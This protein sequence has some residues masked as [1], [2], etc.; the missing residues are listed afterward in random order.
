MSL[1]GLE[2]LLRGLLAPLEH[3][4]ALRVARLDGA[5]G[6]HPPHPHQDQLGDVEVDGDALLLGQGGLF[7]VE[8]ALVPLEDAVDDLLHLELHALPE[9]LGRQRPHLHEGLALPLA[10]VDG[11]DRGLVLL[12]RDLA[13]ADEDLAQAVVREVA[14]GEYDTPVHEVDALAGAA[15]DEGQDAGRL[16][17]AQVLQDVGERAAR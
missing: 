3:E 1:V 7:E 6:V 11:P 5:R 15:G 17:G 10:L 12:D 14:R 13:V 4:Q 16:R 9:V 2:Q 8:G